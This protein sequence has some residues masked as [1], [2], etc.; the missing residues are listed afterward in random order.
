MGVNTAIW[1]S[2]DGHLMLYGSFNDTSVMEQKF[3]W[4]GTTAGTT[5][6]Y[7]EIRSLR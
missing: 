6:T 1:L 5:N 4:Y 2:N 7:P 3:S